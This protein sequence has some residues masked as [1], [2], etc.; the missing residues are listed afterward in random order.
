MRI[1]TAW[2][3][4]LMACA[5]QGQTTEVTGKVHGTV[6]A[7]DGSG[8][9]PGASIAFG[10]LR[11]AVAD[12]SGRY[13]INLP[14]GQYA[15]VARAIGFTE[16]RL[17]VT[18]PPGGE[19]ELDIPMAPSTSQLDMVVVSA[20]KFE[21]RVGEVTQSL[22]VLPAS[23]IR[24]KGTVNLAEALDQVPGVVVV[25]DDP[26]IRSGSGFSYGAGSRVMLLADGLPVLSG[27]IGRPNWTFLPIE[28][29][30][31]IE[32]IKGASSVL[33]GS[34]AL[35]GVINVRTGWPGDEPRTRATLFAGVY[36][37]P[38]N[39]DA[40]WWGPSPP[41]TTGAG[42]LHA[43]R[44][45]QF[46]LVL[47]A[48]A[49]GDQG[50]I[51]PE[52]MAPDSLA[53]HPYELG[54][55]GY[56]HR[57]RFNFATRWRDRKVKGLN[58]GING[59]AMRSHS[60]SVFLWDNLNQGLYRPMPNTTTNTVGTQFYLD[61]FVHYTG[62]KGTRHSLRG[63]WFR[64]QFDNST[65]QSNGND[66]LYGEYQW[67]QQ[68]ELFGPTTIT[69][70]LVGQQVASHAELYSG[71][72]EA[73]GENTAT[74]AAVY[75]QVDKKLMD[76]LML[77]AGVRYERFKV[78]ELEQA[79]PVLRAGATYQVWEGTFLRASYGQGFRFPTIGE[80]YI[81]T[82]VGALHIYPNPELQ[83]EASVNMEAGIKQG[84]K[85]GGVTGYVDMV[86]FRQDFDRYVEFT[87]GQWGADR[88]MANLFGFGFKSVNTGKARITGT[89]FEVAGKGKVG[90]VEVQFLL[91]YTHTLP[92]STTPNE[93]YAQ[94]V[95][96]TGAVQHIS[97]LSTSSDPDN[98]ILK[99]R[100]QDLFRCDVGATWKRFSP[101]IS[102]RYNSHVRNIDEAFIQIEQMGQLGNVGVKQWMA[103]HTTGDWITDARLGFALTPQ[104]KV[105][106][107]VANLTN[108][109]YAIRPMAI[110]APR[111]YRLQLALSI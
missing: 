107:L 108:E 33:Y 46:D 100:V 7:T 10:N 79:E 32:V 8:A 6:S 34:A 49:Y 70:G 44:F 97:Y 43:E 95:T 84:F 37:T 61:P 42:F 94:T 66:L 5:G 102:V 14:A 92:I 21:Q 57:I 60:T 9:V 71:N 22:S 52:R 69:A 39:P 36:D 89:E 72:P 86:A 48:N 73:N 29:V 99:F 41:L 59:N 25:D 19:V 2:A 1:I 24:D 68:V 47:A 11:S 31:Q 75:L 65:N 83:P 62:P 45:K 12:D 103:D 3:F 67:Q 18:V 105:S 109:V 111:S 35:S 51:G 96:T 17:Q 54:T 38:G 53:K 74:N 30:E 55:G 93:A 23:I 98:D 87:F 28:D 64:Q 50:Y 82:S 58:Y 26:Q 106:F 76:R 90:A 63:R 40:K 16:K 20:S 80:R 104:V 88:S 78:N 85:V 91:G 27:D 101:G 13:A 77:S 56:D 81:T 4:A 15:V 110:E